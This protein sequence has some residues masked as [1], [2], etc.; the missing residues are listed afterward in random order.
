MRRL[1]AV[2]ILAMA[3]GL[4]SAGSASAV[5]GN[6]DATCSFTG[7]QLDLYNAQWSLWAPNVTCAGEG[8]QSTLAAGAYLSAVGAN[9]CPTGG[10]NGSFDLYDR[11]GNEVGYGIVSLHF[12]LGVGV[13]SGPF[14]GTGFYWDASGTAAG[15]LESTAAL[16]GC[17][18]STTVNGNVTLAG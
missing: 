11:N 18:G 17:L 7:A 8:H 3:V 14:T 15:V 12:A 13:F 10:G 2:A 5:T 9:Q 16:T 6:F 1:M 4:G